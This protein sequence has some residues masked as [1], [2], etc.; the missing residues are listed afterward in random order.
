MSTEITRQCR[1]GFDVVG[2]RNADLELQA[3]PALGGR[4]ISLRD[5]RADREWIWEPPSNP[6]LRTAALGDSFARSGHTGI[7]D[8]IPTLG[9][10]EW[11][12]RRLP[13]HGEVWSIP[14]EVVSA[15]GDEL[16]LRVT[17]PLTPFVLK[18][19]FRLENA[20]LTIAYQLENLGASPEEFVWTWHPLF[21]ICEGDRLELPPTA[22]VM[23][24]AGIAGTKGA[25]RGDLWPLPS[26]E[27]GYDIER[28]TLGDNITERVKGFVGPFPAGRLET[29]LHGAG[30]ECLRIGWEAA[31]N[32]I[33]GLWLSRGYRGWHHVALE[34]TNG[35]PDRLN[36][37]VNDWHSHGTVAPGEIRRWSLAISTSPATPEALTAESS[38]RRPQNMPPR[39]ASCTHL[40]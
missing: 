13:D 10:C 2:L 7:D 5:R 12:G 11:R 31:E 19:T 37:A 9:D 22:T 4:I 38:T 24:L 35:A 16:T 21:G 8:C 30:G 32:P 6:P 28:L 18:R 14:W 26:P 23:R 27:P 34:P 39:F 17:L 29:A 36:Q 25:R 20:G 3:V 33:L 15:A 1:D 40:V